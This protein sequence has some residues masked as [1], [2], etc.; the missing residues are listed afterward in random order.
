MKLVDDL[1][2]DT[3][4]NI[5]QLELTSNILGVDLIVKVSIKFT[6]FNDRI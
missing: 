4:C 5:T 1:H 2:L 3:D 6:I